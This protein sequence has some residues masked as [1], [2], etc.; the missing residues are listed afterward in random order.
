MAKYH[1][2]ILPFIYTILI[3]LKILCLCLRVKT[4]LIATDLPLHS[5]LEVCQSE[6][7]VGLICLKNMRLF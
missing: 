5:N 3:Y 6:E 7:M 4:D 1:P 2:L